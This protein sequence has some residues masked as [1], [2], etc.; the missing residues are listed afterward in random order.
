MV[1]MSGAT[2]ICQPGN[3]RHTRRSSRC[4]DCRRRAD[5]PR[6]GRRRSGRRAR[7]GRPRQA[8]W[9]GSGRGR[10]HRSWHFRRS[11]LVGGVVLSLDEVY[12]HGC[13][14][15]KRGQGPLVSTPPDHESEGENREMARAAADGKI[16]RSAIG[17]LALPPVPPGLID[18]LRELGPD[19]SSLVSDVLDE[20]GVARTVP[21]S[22]LR[23]IYPD[24]M[25][26]GRA[27]TL[28]NIA[29]SDSPYKGASARISRLARDRG[30]QPRGARRHARHRGP[31]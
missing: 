9:R 13:A 11:S 27:L 8:G 22:V 31:A 19:L 12:V 28:R 21:A 16:A 7:P 1:R 29:Q 23:P 18:G 5:R 3:A 26:V 20:M 10:P 30:A 17:Q 4:R 2:A 15:G 14:S 25:I 6:Q 24:A